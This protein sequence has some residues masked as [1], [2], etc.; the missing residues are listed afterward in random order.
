MDSFWEVLL[1]LLIWFVLGTLSAATIV[2]WAAVL[3]TCLRPCFHKCT[4]DDDRRTSLDQRA[5]DMLNPPC[6]HELTTATLPVLLLNSRP[7]GKKLV[8][9]AE[10]HIKSNHDK[11]EK[12][13]AGDHIHEPVKQLK[14]PTKPRSHS[15]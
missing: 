14:I 15:N 11:A 4:D 10:V 1:N 13:L 5:V 6:T 3:W 12:A 8:I 2:V 9:K 7:L